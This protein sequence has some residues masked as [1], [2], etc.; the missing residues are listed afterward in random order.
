MSEKEKV[1]VTGGS[2]LLGSMMV[3]MLIEEENVTPVVMDI[4][5]NPT[6]LDDVKDEVEYIEGDI[7]GSDHLNNIFSKFKPTKII[8]LAVFPGDLC[9]KDHVHAVDVNVNGF[10]NLMEAARN[11]GVQQLLFSSSG[12]TYGE[13]LE[14]GVML[15]DKTLQRPA[16]FYG[17]TKVFS[18]SVGRWYR[19]RYDFDYRGIH[20]P[21]IIGPGLR[22]AGMVTFASAMIEMPAKGEPYTLPIDKDI[23]L[24][25]VYVEDGARALISLGKAPKEKIKT[26]N[27]FINGVKNPLPNVGEMVDM[28]R[29][30][31]PGAQLDFNVNQDWQKLLQSASHPVDDSSSIAEWNW[32]PL[33]DSWDKVIDAYLRDLNA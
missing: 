1:V 21:A 7:T 19:K 22:A 32:S 6:R 31:I 10:V 20:Y 27:Y 5:P 26:I 2:G 18:E 8:H 17:I 3:H 25:L 11:N 33:Y 24:S 9:E 23:S 29:K 30:K 13:D 28:V 12:T 15:T 4:N 14:Q 16:S